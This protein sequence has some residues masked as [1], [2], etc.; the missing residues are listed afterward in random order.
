MDKEEHKDEEQEDFEFMMEAISDDKE[1]LIA[2]ALAQKTRLDRLSE[3]KE[4]REKLDVANLSEEQLDS[5]N[6]AIS[7]E[8]NEIDDNFYKVKTRL[9]EKA[10]ARKR[11]E[12]VRL[13]QQNANLRAG[14]KVYPN[15]P[16]P[17]G[18][19]KKYKKCCGKGY[20]MI[21]TKPENIS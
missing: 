8:L 11:A 12:V 21:K 7:D 6:K 19:G 2:Y 10:V 9:L 20:E 13:K 18:S 5:E 15:D 16:C 14:H 3:I 17:C 1:S 4:K